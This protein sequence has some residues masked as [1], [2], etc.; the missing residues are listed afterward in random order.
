MKR[1]F[2]YKMIFS[3]DFPNSVRDFVINPVKSMN[4]LLAKLVSA[5]DRIIS[6]IPP[7][8]PPPHYIRLIIKVM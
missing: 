4:T 2:K 1:A 8:P 3:A 7:P 6:A 5:Q